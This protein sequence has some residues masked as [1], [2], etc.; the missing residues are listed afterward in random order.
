MVVFSQDTRN[1]SEKDSSNRSELDCELSVFLSGLFLSSFLVSFCF[2]SFFSLF[3]LNHNTNLT[4]TQNRNRVEIGVDEGNPK[5]ERLERKQGRANR[6]KW[7]RIQDG[8]RI[9]H[10]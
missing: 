9:Q 10:K 3:F 1:A 5:Q 4:R 7:R 8:N 2:S 6:W